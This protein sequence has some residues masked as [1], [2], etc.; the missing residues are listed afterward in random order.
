MTTQPD[1]AKV[2]SRCD[3]LRIVVAQTSPHRVDAVKSLAIKSAGR[4]N[5]VITQMLRKSPG[6]GL[7]EAQARAD[8][9]VACV[10]LDDFS[11]Y[12]LWCDGRHHSS[13]PLKPGAIHINDM[14]HKWHADIRG[15]F[16]VVNFYI[17]QGVLD[18]IAEEHGAA[19]IEEVTCPIDRGH[20]D[21]TFT[22]LALALLPA[23]AQ[24][25]QTN[26]LF[27]EHAA[28]T[29]AVHVAWSYGSSTFQLQRSRGGLA[30]WQERR[31][32]ELLSADLSGNT[33]VQ[34][35]ASACN[36]SPSHFSQAFRQTVGAPPHQWLLVQR[37]ERAKQLLL[38]T[39]E[40]LC[41]IALASGFA[42]QSH[43]TR[44][45]SKQIKASPAAWRRAQ[46]K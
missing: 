10:H 45:F 26:N 20:T 42:D 34:E 30:P 29:V 33:S 31:A 21:A 19:R 35:L 27:A 43:F 25:R 28:K 41:Q 22:N 18:E 11:S 1:S 32:K 12:D 44:V 36:L 40:P 6:H 17:P 39:K 15:A 14:R 5:F 3:D 24:P 23:L 37:V 13:R 46:G 9:Y 4:D 8:A 7:T 2:G 38:N 16:N